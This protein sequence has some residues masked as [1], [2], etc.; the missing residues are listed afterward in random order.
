MGRAWGHGPPTLAVAASR[1]EVGNVVSKNHITCYRDDPI[2]QLGPGFVSTA[3][4]IPQ[5]SCV[6]VTSCF[7]FLYNSFYTSVPYNVCGAKGGWKAR[8]KSFGQQRCVNLR[9]E[10]SR[11]YVIFSSRFII[12]WYGLFTRGIPIRHSMSSVITPKMVPSWRPLDLMKE[13]ISRAWKTQPNAH[14][15]G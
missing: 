2:I 14:F 1:T 5:G 10:P 9:S 11:W 13:S 6:F 7:F 15:R 3:I 8:D 12:L 4:R